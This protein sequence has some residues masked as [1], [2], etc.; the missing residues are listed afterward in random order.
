MIPL[1][2]GIAESDAACVGQLR[3]LAAALG[4]SSTFGVHRVSCEATISPTSVRL[5]ASAIN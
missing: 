5:G 1:A 2:N 4:G 3:P